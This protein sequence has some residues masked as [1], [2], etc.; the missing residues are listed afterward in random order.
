MVVHPTP[1]LSARVRELSGMKIGNGTEYEPNK[2]KWL[3]QAPFVPIVCFPQA[4]DTTATNICHLFSYC[5][6][7]LKYLILEK[8]NSGDCR[9]GGIERLRRKAMRSVSVICPR[10]CWQSESR[11]WTRLTTKLRVGS[12]TEVSSSKYR[13]PS[14]MVCSVLVYILDDIENQSFVH[15]CPWV[16]NQMVFVLVFVLNIPQRLKGCTLVSTTG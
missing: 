12:T 9:T 2:Q 16:P 15:G 10:S 14:S 1:A 11:C 6:T 7:Y 8:Y 4:F 5:Y 3:S 13:I